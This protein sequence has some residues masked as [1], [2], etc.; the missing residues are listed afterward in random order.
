MKQQRMDFKKTDASA[1]VVIHIH[2]NRIHI[3][4]DLHMGRE[5]KARRT[6][7]REEGRRGWVSRDGDF[8]QKQQRI[9]TEL[10]EFLDSLELPTEVADMLPRQQAMTG[11]EMPQVNPALSDS[12]GG[13]S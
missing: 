10:A 5:F 13:D 1:T 9:G 3:K 2:R 8:S 12:A 7:V 11:A 4:A 6:F